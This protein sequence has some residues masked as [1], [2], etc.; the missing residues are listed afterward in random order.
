MVHS[1]AEFANI[2]EAN[3]EFQERRKF[4]RLVSARRYADLVNC[5]PKAIAGMRVV[6]AQVGRPLSGSGADEDQS[7]LIPKLVG[8]HFQRVRTLFVKSGDAGNEWLVLITA[9]R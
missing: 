9:F 3:S 7:Q 2:G 5:A 6:M 4:M 8:K 1:S